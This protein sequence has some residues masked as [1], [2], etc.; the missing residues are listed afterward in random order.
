MWHKTSIRLHTLDY[1]N[2]LWE[3]GHSVLQLAKARLLFLLLLAHGNMD[4]HDDKN[5]LTEVVSHLLCISR[6]AFFKFLLN[7]YLKKKK[8]HNPQILPSV[9][10]VWNYFGCFLGVPCFLFCHRWLAMVIASTLADI[11]FAGIRLNCFLSELYLNRVSI[12]LVV[13]L[14]GPMPASLAISSVSGQ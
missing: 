6:V 11:V 12:I 4:T 7:S 13:M 5:T 14:L 8:K 1:P 10:V 2:S 9:P 3:A